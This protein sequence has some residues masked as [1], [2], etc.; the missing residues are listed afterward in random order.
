LLQLS[1]E[2]EPAVL[3]RVGCGIWTDGCFEPEEIEGAMIK[4]ATME[5]RNGT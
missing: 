4:L 5:R 1:W 2:N 3:K